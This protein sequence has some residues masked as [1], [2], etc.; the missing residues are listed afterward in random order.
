MRSCNEWHQKQGT[1]VTS[2]IS[3]V[4]ECLNF[5]FY[6]LCW[7]RENAGMG[8]MKLSR[9]LCMSHKTGSLMLFWILMEK[10]RVV[11]QTSVQRTISLKKQEEV[12]INRMKAYAEAIKQKLR[13]PA[14]ILELDRK[15]NPYNWS[16]HP[17]QNDLEFQEE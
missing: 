6:D 13:D 9:W 1:L 15:L 16:S 11:S 10:Y 3:N 17:F 5:M 12:N 8:D 7:C 14:H 4:F 2:K